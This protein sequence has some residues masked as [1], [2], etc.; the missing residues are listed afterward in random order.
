MMPTYI[1][2]DYSGQGAALKLNSSI[3]YQYIKLIRSPIFFNQT[4]T[5]SVWLNPNVQASVVYA[6]FTQT[7]LS[8]PDLAISIINQY[9]VL[10]VYKTL[11]WSTTKLKNFCWQYVTFVFFRDDLSMAIFIDG[12]VNAQGTIDN[13]EYGNFKIE[14]T[15]I[16]SYDVFSQYNGLMDQFSIAFRIKNRMDTLDEAT[17]V[18]YYTFEDDGQ[19]NDFL[20]SRCWCE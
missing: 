16:G 14:E 2:P 19:Y 8:A 6:I 12:I 9:A 3:K 1:T 20:F 13:P 10:R 11:L 15:F 4:F 18:A 5:I 17:L 7:Y